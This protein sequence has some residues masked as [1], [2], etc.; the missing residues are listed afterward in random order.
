VR[1]KESK[2]RGERVDNIVRGRAR[3]LGG[4]VDVPLEYGYKDVLIPTTG[5]NRKLTTP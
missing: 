1:S 3:L 5:F 2:D 4:E